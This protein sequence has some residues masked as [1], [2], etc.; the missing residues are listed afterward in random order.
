MMLSHPQ[1]LAAGHETRGGG[2]QRSGNETRKT[3]KITF[4]DV[5]IT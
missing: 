5:M 1:T 2:K 4:G 3:G